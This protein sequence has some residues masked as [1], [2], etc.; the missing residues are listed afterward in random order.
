MKPAPQPTWDELVA[1]GSS[2]ERLTAAETVLL[3]SYVNRSQDPV[4]IMETWEKL[5]KNGK[6]MLVL[7]PYIEDKMVAVARGKLGRWWG[8][9]DDEVMVPSYCDKFPGA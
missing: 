9:D 6:N 4:R 7:H 3:G 1:K 8:H 5:Q 2:T